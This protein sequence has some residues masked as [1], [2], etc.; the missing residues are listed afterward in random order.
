MPIAALCFSL[1]KGDQEGVKQLLRTSAATMTTVY[2]TKYAT[3]C[4]RPYGGMYSFPSGHTAGAFM[5]AAYLDKRYGFAFSFPG[6][7]I[8]SVV[9][10]SRTQSHKHHMRDVAMGAFIAYVSA[11]ILTTPYENNCVVITPICEEGC[12]GLSLSKRF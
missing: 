1:S 4:T 3:R 7:I 8:S 12:N 6:V 10:Y 2:A 9:G 11:W 5:G